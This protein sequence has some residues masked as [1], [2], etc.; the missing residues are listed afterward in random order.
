M[1]NFIT[2]W[3]YWHNQVKESV[4]IRALEK[5]SFKIQEIDLEERGY[6]TVEDVVCFINLNTDH[7]FRN[8]DVINMFKR[9][10]GKTDKFDNHLSY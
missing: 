1:S 7:C 3:D 2:S 9:L 8:R 4:S 6:I 5:E 10:N